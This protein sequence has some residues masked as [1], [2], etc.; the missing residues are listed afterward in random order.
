MAKKEWPK[1]SPKLLEKTHHLMHDGFHQRAFPDTPYELPEAL[2][3][4]L[5]TEIT[6]TIQ[7]VTEAM[8][9]YKVHE[10]LGTSMDLARVGNS[11]V[12]D[13]QPWFQAKNPEASADLDQT[14]ATLTRTLTVLCALFEPVAPAKMAEMAL[15]LGLDGVPTLA[16]A[17]SLELAGRRVSKGKPLFP[18]IEPSWTG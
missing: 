11:Y 13:R 17:R 7:K 8:M 12:D 3:D 6:E 14:L 2:G 9:G 1:P 10:A 18:R 4:G 15:N 16:A 5:D